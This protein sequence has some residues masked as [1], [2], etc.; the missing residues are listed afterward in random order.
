MGKL[1]VKSKLELISLYKSGNSTKRIISIMGCK[2][3]VISRNQVN[4]WIN[5]Y[6]SGRFTF[7]EINE[8]GHSWAPR[9]LFQWDIDFIREAF[10]K[11]PNVSSTD[12]HKQLT[13]QGATF[14][15]S[16]TK[17]AIQLA[18][19]TSATPRYAQLVSVANKIVRKAFCQSLLERNDTFDD[20]IFT[21]ESSIQLHS[22]KRTSYRPKHSVNTCMPKPKH[23]LKLHVWAGISRRGPT[24]ITI[25]EGIMDSEFY[26][27]SILR[28]NL[29]PFIHSRFPN[30]HRFQQDNDPKHRSRMAMAFM[31]SNGIN[32]QKWPAQS[33][34]LNPIEMVWN[35]LKGYVSKCEIESFWITL[36]TADQCN[37]YIDNLFKVVPIC[38]KMNGCATGDTPNRIFRQES[39]GKSIMYFNNLLDTD[40]RTRETA[41]LLLPG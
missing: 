10:R 3:I 26:T 28:D 35:Q 37:K 20:V 39:R 40:E 19:Y 36:M 23:P 1:D 27:N 13:E 24:K 21:D 38:I 31:E 25:F 15:L 41:S 2:G 34:D 5:S 4:Y 6:E 29:V 18:G 30:T 16:T 22:N 8:R 7:D 17:R 32:N 33:P 12:I 14:S 9:K 11:D